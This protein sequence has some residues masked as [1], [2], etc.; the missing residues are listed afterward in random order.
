M[1]VVL[2]VSPLSNPVH[3]AAP[4]LHTEHADHGTSVRRHPGC[5][6]GVQCTVARGKLLHPSTRPRVTVVD[7]VTDVVAVVGSVV[8]DVD[9]VLSAVVPICTAGWG[10]VLLLGRSHAAC[11]RTLC[12]DPLQLPAKVRRVHSGSLICLVRGCLTI[13]AGCTLCP[14]CGVVQTVTCGWYWWLVA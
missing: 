2:C 1:Y 13:G 7:V 3:S 12:V 4:V 11:Q 8:V 9:A 6:Q 14:P 5:I 10:H